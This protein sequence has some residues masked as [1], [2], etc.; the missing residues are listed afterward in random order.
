ML[1]K[2]NIQKQEEVYNQ[3][4]RKWRKSRGN[5]KRSK[6]LCSIKNLLPLQNKLPWTIQNLVRTNYHKTHL[7]NAMYWFKVN[8][9]LWIWWLCWNLVI[10]LVCACVYL[11]ILFIDYYPLANQIGLWNVVTNWPHCRNYKHKLLIDDISDQSRWVDNN[12]CL[13]FFR[14]RNTETSSFDV[15]EKL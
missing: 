4:N 1:T 9:I 14:L 13:L 3:S 6:L 15:A 8:D 7:L 5:I 12:Y 2:T 10:M 11:T